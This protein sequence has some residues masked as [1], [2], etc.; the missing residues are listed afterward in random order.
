LGEGNSTH[1]SS[2]KRRKKVQWRTQT[3]GKRGRPAT[4]A[5]RR[6]CPLKKNGGFLEVPTWQKSRNHSDEKTDQK[7]KPHAKRTATARRTRVC[8]IS[9][10][11]DIRGGG[12][13]VLSPHLMVH[14]RG[15]VLSRRGAPKSQKKRSKMD[16]GE[17]RTSVITRKK[18]K[19]G[20]AFQKVH[21][22]CPL[23]Q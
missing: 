16:F 4:S 14:E 3:S 5:L 17:K 23:N 9:S 22:Q 6:T 19:E 2:H 18:Y 20:T 8:F 11:F 13:H 10:L 15:E 12:L 7:G 21:F 1:L